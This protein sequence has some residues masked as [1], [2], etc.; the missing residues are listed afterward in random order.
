MYG[1]LF[2]QQ[3]KH[4]RQWIDA[5]VAAGPQPVKLD[6]MV[7]VMFWTAV[8]YVPQVRIEVLAHPQGFRVCA[9]GAPQVKPGGSSA[10]GLPAAQSGHR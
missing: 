10:L 9:G 2:G 6:Y 5:D 3:T 7:S 4:L 8:P 1:A